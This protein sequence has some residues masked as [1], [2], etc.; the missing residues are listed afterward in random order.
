MLWML[1]HWRWYGSW[2]IMTAIWILLS[3][4]GLVDISYILWF[5]WLWIVW[6]LLYG[7][8][9]EWEKVY[10]GLWRYENLDEDEVRVLKLLY[11]RWT[12]KGQ[13]RTYIIAQEDSNYESQDFSY[14]DDI[15]IT[16]LEQT[17]YIHV[18]KKTPTTWHTSVEYEI[19]PKWYKYIQ[20][21][22]ADLT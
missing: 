16:Q 15:F 6:W 14:N 1:S 22:H 5:W 2:T 21:N 10:D 9:K 12:Q 18:F 4:Q 17:W 11:S 19:R 8:Y 3:Q 20:N 13:Q 7:G